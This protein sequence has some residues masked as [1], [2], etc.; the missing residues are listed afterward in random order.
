MAAKT[1]KTTKTL[2]SVRELKTWL[3][4]YCSAHGKEWSPTPEQ[5]NLIKGKI[6]SLDDSNSQYPAPVHAPVRHAPVE[7]TYPHET[8]T[9]GVQRSSTIEA[10][11]YE[12]YSG[13]GT[14]GVSERPTMYQKDGKLV[15]PSSLDD[16]G[17]PSAFA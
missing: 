6:F 1:K 16:A 17:G 3:D 10:P 5:W 8:V 4:G 15:M 2:V 14:V 9:G 12:G 11:S 7:A 13:G